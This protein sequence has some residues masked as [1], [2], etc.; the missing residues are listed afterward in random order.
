MI[1]FVIIIY[2]WICPEISLNCDLF[3]HRKQAS[4]Q[5]ANSR[6]SH[7]FHPHTPSQRKRNAY[8]QELWEY[9]L[10]ESPCHYRSLSSLMFSLKIPTDICILYHNIAELR[11]RRDASC[12]AHG[13]PDHLDMLFSSRS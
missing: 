12:S 9:K 11:V 6:A 1:G 3:I 8:C 5:T 7:S 10:K 2:T 13:F 4:A